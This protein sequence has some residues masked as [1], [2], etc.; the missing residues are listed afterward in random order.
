MFALRGM[1]R[2]TVLIACATGSSVGCGFE[3]LFPPLPVVENVDLA[4]YAGTWYEIARYPNGFEEGCTGVTAEYTVRE[5]GTVRVVNTCREST[6]DGPVWQIE[7]F[8]ESADATTN[9]KLTVY[10]FFP[11]GAPYWIIEL[12]EDYQYAVVGEPSRSFLWILSRTPTL[13]AATYQSILDGLPAQG[14]DPGRLELT[15]QAT[16]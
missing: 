3:A 15:P 13:D 6:L 8:A 10:F 14:Y 7:G 5:D 1:M 12:D 4:R 16:D 9:A 2:L 11:F